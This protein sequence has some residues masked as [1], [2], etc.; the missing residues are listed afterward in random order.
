MEI[1]DLALTPLIHLC[2]AEF[3]KAKGL[4]QGMDEARN[5]LHGSKFEVQITASDAQRT[6]GLEG[7]ACSSQVAKVVATHCDHMERSWGWIADVAVG[8]GTLMSMPLALLLV[9]YAAAMPIP[10]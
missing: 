9:R 4:R 6:F 3:Y 8:E 7:T 1:H 5:L 10:H 2:C